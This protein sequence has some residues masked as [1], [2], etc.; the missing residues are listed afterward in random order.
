MALERQKFMRRSA[1]PV[2]RFGRQLPQRLGHFA[3]SAIRLGSLTGCRD[4]DGSYSMFEFDMGMLRV[5]LELEVG[6]RCNP[7]H[8][9]ETARPKV[10]VFKPL[11]YRYPP[12]LQ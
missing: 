4:P 2:Q 10:S 12:G 9:V 5:G 11:A 3:L 7:P 1:R 6:A 8:E